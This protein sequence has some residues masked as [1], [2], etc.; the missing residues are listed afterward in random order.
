MEKLAV[1]VNDHLNDD[2]TRLIL[3]RAKWPG[4]DMDL[5]VNCIESRRKLRGK[6]QEWYDE[7][8][9]IFPY[10][11]SAEQCSS[12]ATA[13]YKADLAVRIALTRHSGLLTARHSGLLP[14]RHSGLD[15]ESP[16]YKI[17]DLTGGLGVDSW[18]FSQKASEV[19]YNEMQPKLC[20]AAAHNF[21]ILKSNNIHCSCA[22]V[23]PGS[24]KE[25]LGGFSPDII[26]MDPARRGEGGRKVFL[27]EDCTPDV[28]TLKD[29]IFGICRHILLKLSPM[30]DITMACDRLGRTCREVH[31]VA[32]AGE[33]KELLVWMDREWDDEYT[34]N[35]VELTNERHSGRTTRHSG[36]LTARH[37]GL[38]PDPPSAFT[39][40]PSEEKSASCT[41]GAEGRYL[42]E[43]GKALMKSGAFNLISNR[44]GISKLGQSTHFYLTDDDA[45]AA[46][47]MDHGKIFEIISSSPLDKRSIKAAAQAC[48]KAEVTARNIPMDTDTLRKKLGTA[49][50]DE[51]HIFGLKSDAKGAI[52]LITKRITI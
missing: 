26:F 38:D 8:G 22:K 10:K 27:I 30:A 23:E 42:F 37:S 21:N 20:E 41:L 40:T 13:R 12:S 51:Y 50:S 11:L 52:L 24:I 45:T 44:F 15:P 34:I 16:S 17:A 25:I 14:A 33:C 48:P 9:L 7:P 32:A 28:L 46:S 29:E 43:P 18:F 31:V 47:L 3:D 4:I 2:T 35:A 6:V 36:L 1:F 49:P 19:L 39:F 5:A